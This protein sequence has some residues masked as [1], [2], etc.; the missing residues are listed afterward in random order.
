MERKA[1]ENLNLHIPYPCEASRDH[2][3]EVDNAANS[4]SDEEFADEMEEVLILLKKEYD[5]FI[6]FQSD[7]DGRSREQVIE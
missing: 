3:E 1:R 4:L 7:E 5:D 6:F 2:I